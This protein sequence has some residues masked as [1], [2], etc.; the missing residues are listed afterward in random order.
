MQRKSNNPS[1]PSHIRAFRHHDADSQLEH[2]RRLLGLSHEFEVMDP[3]RPQRLARAL[4][5]ARRAAC[6]GF[7]DYDPVR[8]LV[9]A[10][11]LRSIGLPGLSG[12]GDERKKRKHARED[13]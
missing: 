13:V 10:R 5:M 1:Q 12:C 9:L 6:G 2:A 7:G 4:R 3:S 11:Y 8:H